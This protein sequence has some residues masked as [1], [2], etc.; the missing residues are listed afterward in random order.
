M[1]SEN[2][3]HSI[4]NRAISNFKEDFVTLS[5]DLYTSQDSL[6]HPGEFGRYRENL[7]SDLLKN[8]VPSYCNVKDGFIINCLGDVTTQCDIIIYDAHE[9][10]SHQFDRT[11]PFFP[12]ETCYGV[13]EVKSVLKK[14]DLIQALKKLQNIKKIRDGAQKGKL[15]IKPSHIID[16]IIHVVRNEKVDSNDLDRFESQNIVTFLICERFDFDTKNLQKVFES[17]IYD[18]GDVHF[19]HNLILSLEDGFFSFW[20]KNREIIKIHGDSPETIPFPFPSHDGVACGNRFM[21]AND[22][23]DH[24]FCFLSELAWAI[25]DTCIYPYSYHAYATKSTYFENRW[26]MTN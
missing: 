1:A 9:A 18:P 22:E 10:P 24:I 13:G 14:C 26:K 21:S 8:I 23:N 4:T 19:R 15:P 12:Q 20:F 5:R 2:S 25:S 17:E 16:K 11:R 6:T 3:Y 7:V